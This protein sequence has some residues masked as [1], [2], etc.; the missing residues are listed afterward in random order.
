MPNT[1]PAPV[2]VAL[3]IL[4]GVA[5]THPLHLSSAD[6]SSRPAGTSG[7]SATMD[8]SAALGDTAARTEGTGGT[9]GSTT[10]GTGSGGAAGAGG[11]IGTGGA[12]TAG[13]TI[14]SGGATSAGGRMGLAGAT[15]TGGT[16]STGG[17]NRCPSNPAMIS[18]FESSPGKA[19]MN[20]QDGRSSGYWYVY[21]PGSDTSSVP[22]RGMSQTPALSPGKPI[23]TESAPDASTCNQ[24]ALHSTGSGFSTSATSPVGFGASFMPHVPAD[25]QSDAYDVSRYTGISFKMKSGSGTPP[26]VFFEVLTKDSQP[27]NAGGTATN[28][29]ID[30]NNTRGQ[31]L[32]SPWTPNE[33]STNYQ[34]FTVPFGTL[35][36]RW[37]PSSVRRHER[38][39]VCTSGASEP[40]CQAPPFLSKNVL[41]IRLS[42]YLDDGIPK[43]AGSTAGSY[44]LW[45]D[46]VMFVEKDAGLQTRAGFPLTNPGSFGKCIKPRGP[47]ADAKFLV[48]AYNQWKATFVRDNKVIRPENK[49]DTLSEGIA[50]G[51]MIAVN[52][53]DQGLLDGLYGTWKS[54]PATGTS[55]L[56]KSCLGGSG[57]GKAGESCSPSDGSAT[58]ADEDA[59]YA[60]LMAGKL[61]GGTYQADAI[62]MLKDIWDKDMDGA[63]TKLPKGGSNDQ[64]PTGTGTG[65]ITSASYFAPS[66]YRSFASVDPD[67]SHDWTGVIAAVY[68]A[69]L[70]IAGGTGLIPAWC[71]NSCTVAASHGME[72]DVYYQYDS[73]RIP[74]R[75]GLDY[76]FHETTEAKTYTDLTTKFFSGAAN[77]GTGFVYDM[78]TP[79][80]SASSGITTGA[81]SVLGTAAAGAMASANQTFLDAAYQTVFDVA[82]RGTLA[83][84]LVMEPSPAP[85][86]L[87]ILPQTYGY[88]NATIGMLTLLIMTGNFMH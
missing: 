81:A 16:S 63:A 69:I 18:D 20:Q 53:N 45:I 74:M 41:G 21:F 1:Q 67:T 9:W 12:S 37:L 33:I 60:L 72:N 11:W 8:A 34:T 65:Q 62:A 87:P 27:E 82:T 6:G 28:E 35:V 2:P 80:G 68:K 47:S 15:G 3:A 10:V 55:M 49:D 38:E 4:L 56:M 19:D 85:V 44:D 51:M 78:Y 30:L 23:A 29:V 39:I 13:G 73:H 86:S 52:M 66:F 59:A 14:G 54:N 58:G 79:S 25:R 40:K 70:G 64:S 83:P 84:P 22:A 42:M 88:Y 75:I 36:P 17:D 77:Q 43:P 76:C 7:Q 50:F 61:W 57:S 5:C 32:N 26:A 48:P 71:G 31:L 46:D 24:S